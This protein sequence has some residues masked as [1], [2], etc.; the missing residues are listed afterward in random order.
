MALGVG[1]CAL[2]AVCCVSAL[3]AIAT[4]P[5]MRTRRLHH[6]HHNRA[7]AAPRRVMR[8]A[9]TQVRDLP[10]DT[11]LLVAV[12]ELSEGRPLALVGAT[13]MALFSKKG[14]LKTGQQTLQVWPGAAPDVQQPQRLAGKPPLAARSQVGHLQHLAKLYSRGDIPHCEW[15]DTLTF[16]VRAVL[17][18]CVAPLCHCAAV[19]H[20][21]QM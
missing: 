11:H 19:R 20:M 8:A 12:Y 15:L 3:P 14:R 21:P 9:T 5:H 10:S 7:H 2:C 6:H 13:G 17:L 4:A 16:R 18:L 1:C